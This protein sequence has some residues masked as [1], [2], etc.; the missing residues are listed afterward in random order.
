MKAAPSLEKT[1]S[2]YAE[3]RALVTG[4]TAIQGANGKFSNLEESLVRNV[5]RR[6]FGQ[7]KAR[8]II[9]LDR[10]PPA[11]IAKLLAQIDSGDGQ[12]RLRPSRRG[13]RH[14]VAQR[15]RGA[16]E[17]RAA[18]AGDGDHPRHGA[19]AERP[20]RGRGRRR[21]A[22]LVAPEQP[23]PVRRDDPGRGRDRAGIPVGLGADWLP[24]GSPSLLAELKVA[25][26]SLIEEGHP[27]TAR[28][29]VRMVTIDAARDRRARGQ[30]RPARGGAARRRPR[31][32]AAPSG[33][34]GGG[35]PGGAVVGRAR[36]AGRGRRVR[37]RRLGAE[38]AGPCA[39]EPDPGRTEAPDRLGQAGARR[40]ELQR[41]TPATPP[42]RLADLR[43]EL[44]AR[45]PQVGPIFA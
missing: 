15:V 32:R 45:Y 22:R 8:S 4:T 33:S 23:A 40:H 28:Q 25:R 41:R 29:L 43:A 6:I 24:S 37:P 18:D 7:H 5:D 39:G 20:R 26:Q 36:R 1:L 16:R 34:V 42:P 35:R 38:L 30:A 19:G 17:R 3:A 21:E 13:G 9:D 2:R 10:T 11:D 31:P 14:D 12:R 44:I 27:A